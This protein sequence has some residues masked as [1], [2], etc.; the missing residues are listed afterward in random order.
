M[1]GSEKKM[2]DAGLNGMEMKFFCGIGMS[3]LGRKGL[4]VDL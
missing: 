1:R 4:K 3:I 2:V